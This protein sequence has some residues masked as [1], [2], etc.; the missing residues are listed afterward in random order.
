MK[1]THA[2]SKKTVIRPLPLSVWLAYLLVCTLLLTGV[3]FARYTVT[4]SGDDTARAAAGQVTVD[5][6]DNTNITLAASSTD[7]AEASYTFS[8]SNNG[9]EVAIQYD[10]VVTMQEPLPQGV[11]MKLDGESCT[12]S[13]ES[14]GEAVYEFSDVDIFEA[15]GD[16]TNNHI[17]TFAKESG[18]ST[19][20]TEN[21]EYNIQIA[22]RA[23]QID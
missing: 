3:S 1:P 16:R 10:V 7:G 13:D 19:S 17:L 21:K 12:K 5:W 14:T 15:N 6:A 23:Q 20:G 8:V 4:N 9:S 11:T 2:P 22:V 18:S